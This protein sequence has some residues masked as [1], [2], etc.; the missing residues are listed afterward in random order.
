M[1]RQ[2]QHDNPNT[3]SFYLQSFRSVVALNLWKHYINSI[4]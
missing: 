3:N 1:L 2:A 4:N